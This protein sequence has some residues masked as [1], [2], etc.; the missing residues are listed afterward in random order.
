[1]HKASKSCYFKNNVILKRTRRNA[2]KK[3]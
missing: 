1:M 2:R 3:Y